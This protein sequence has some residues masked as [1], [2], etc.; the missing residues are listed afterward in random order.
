MKPYDVNFI[1]LTI[2][3][4]L[5]HI[6]FV[7]YEHTYHII[8]ST[9]PYVPVIIDLRVLVYT[10]EL[11]DNQKRSTSHY[12]HLRKLRLANACL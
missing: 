5:S 6:Y 3:S 8:Q 10:G 11:T 7:W 9:L 1:Q 12:P 2:L 4:L